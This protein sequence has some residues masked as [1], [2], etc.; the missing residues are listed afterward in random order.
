MLFIQLFDVLVTD[1]KVTIINRDLA[2]IVAMFV[3]ADVIAIGIS[4]G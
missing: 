3:M 1:V 4:V 2:N